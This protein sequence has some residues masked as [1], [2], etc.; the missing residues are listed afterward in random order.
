MIARRLRILYVM[1]CD[2]RWIKQRPHFLAEQL[3]RKHRVIVL[4]PRDPRRTGWPRNRSRVLRIPFLRAPRWTGKWGKYNVLLQKLWIALVALFFKPDC[5]WVTFP[6][7]YF[8]LPQSLKRLPIVYDC[9]DV[10]QELLEGQS[11]VH[12][13]AR[14]ENDLIQNAAAV[15]CSSQYLYDAVVAPRKTYADTRVFL[16]RN[17]ISGDMLVR[18]QSEDTKT[19]VTSP[20][21]HRDTLNIAYIGTI[22]KW[23]DFDA[24]LYCL[25]RVDCLQLHLVGPVETAHVEHDR[26]VHHGVVEHDVLREYASRFDG[27]ILPFALTTLTRGVDPVKLYEYVAFGREVFSIYYEEIDRFGP[28]VHFYRSR[29]ELAQLLVRFRNGVLP[30]KADPMQA[31]SLLRESTWA[32]R[33]HDVD[34]IL[35]RTVYRHP[36]RIGDEEVVGRAQAGYDVDA[37]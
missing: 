33:A 1:H 3:T 18:C 29:E 8:F 10:A 31:Q 13:I 7:L 28:Y 34:M 27:F 20:T 32:R 23:L 21:E 11:E 37:R 25:E 19:E 36:A 15:I 16:V 30:R 24:L 14:L 35:R 12:M 9:M 6:N 4:Y 17:G 2:W 26:L 22:A 5:V